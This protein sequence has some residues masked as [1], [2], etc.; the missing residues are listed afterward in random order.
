MTHIAFIISAGCWLTL[1]SLEFI[2]VNVFAAQLMLW[3]YVC[4]RFKVQGSRFLYLSGLY[5]KMQVVVLNAILE[6]MIF[7]GVS[8]EDEFRSFTAQGKNLLC[9]LVVEPQI[10]YLLAARWAD[11]GWGECYFFSI[12]WPTDICADIFP[13]ITDVCWLVSVPMMPG[14]VLVNQLNKSIILNQSAMTYFR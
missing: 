10:L 14:T 2:L 1:V 9:S 13:D 4:H 5:N 12:L 8:V 6:K 7:P 3:Q 11:H